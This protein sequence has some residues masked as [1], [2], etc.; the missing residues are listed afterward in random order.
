MA[1]PMRPVSKAEVRQLLREMNCR[2]DPELF[3]EIPGDAYRL[4][5]GRILFVSSDY[6]DEDEDDSA[7]LGA[8]WSSLDVLLASTVT[9]GGPRHILQG[10]LPPGEHFVTAIPDLIQAL[11]VQLKLPFSFFDYSRHSLLALDRLIRERFEPAQRIE[12]VLFA[13]VVA[14]VGEIIRRTTGGR[15]DMRQLPQTEIWEPWI[16][17]PSGVE[18]APFATVFKE[19]YDHSDEIGCLAG[20][21]PVA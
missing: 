11:A 10:R 6:A 15:W 13:P 20:A 12:P 9:T 19:L 17:T 7:I 18:Y 3:S 4:E 1:L 8:L 16:V 2:R 14:Y 5:D 21:I